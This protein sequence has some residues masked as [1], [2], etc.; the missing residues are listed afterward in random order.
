MNYQKTMIDALEHRTGIV[1]TSGKSNFA[2]TG[3]LTGLAIIENGLDQNVS[4]QLQGR[5]RGGTTWQDVETAVIVLAG[6]GAGSIAV[7][8]PWSEVRISCTPAGVPTTGAF[9]AWFSGV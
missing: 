5:A 1:F 9:S 8:A 6:G 4:V 7:T 3:A 2:Y